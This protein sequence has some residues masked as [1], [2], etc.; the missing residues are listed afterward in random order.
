MDVYKA[1]FVDLFTSFSDTHSPQPDDVKRVGDTD[2]QTSVVTTASSEQCHGR[3]KCIHYRGNVL[4]S[5]DVWSVHREHGYNA[6]YV[7]GA[8]GRPSVPGSEF[9]SQTA[10]HILLTDQFLNRSATM[11][12][13]RGPGN[14]LTRPDR[15]TFSALVYVSC[16]FCSDIDLNNNELISLY[17]YINICISS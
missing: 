16:T 7:C 10:I 3:V 8:T 11:F 17:T 13:Y 6:V 9:G 15:F 12:E 14:P 5:V 4:N 1:T 2:T